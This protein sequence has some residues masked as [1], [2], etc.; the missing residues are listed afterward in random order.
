MED[1][2]F[3]SR[4]DE[5]AAWW[6]EGAG[7]GPESGRPCVVMAHGFGG[8]RDS[9]LLPF[10][11]GLAEA[12]AHVLLFDY[13]GF[14]D[15]TGEPRQWVSLKRHRE[16]YRAA[17]AFAR[18]REGVDPERI[19]LWGTSYAGGHVVAVA[20][21]DPR[22][23]AAIVMCPHLDGVVTTRAALRAAGPAVM[24]RM[25]WAGIR[26]A[27]GAL[28]GRPP[29][30][31]PIVGPPGSAAAMTTPDAQEGMEAI[32][33]PS[34]RNEFCA[35]EMLVFG[36]DRPGRRADRLPCPILIQIADR[37]DVTP[38]EAAEDAAWRATGRAEVRR[39]PVGHFELY[40]EPTRDRVLADQRLFLTRRLMAESLD[41]VV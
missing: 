23:A 32:A 36:S 39:Y 8:T 9:G 18:G 41:K 1:V 33:G 38:P 26:D 19:V 22:I 12:G 11:E 14:G 4:G 34:W 30:L 25:T 35:R 40:V 17:I 24:A 6:L 2:R 27:A 3:E 28:R 37:D 15:S 16:D 21:E 29:V 5:C 10:A 13:R 20:V 7:E 31:L